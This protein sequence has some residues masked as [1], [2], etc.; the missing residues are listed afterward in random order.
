MASFIPTRPYRNW[1]SSL[2][3]TFD[4][5]QQELNLDLIPNLMGDPQFTKNIPFTS[6]CS[7]FRH[8]F[9][10]K[11]AFSKHSKLAVPEDQKL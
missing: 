8:K 1:G 7:T 3:L 5:F 4:I 10:L 9:L 6:S 2:G 11:A